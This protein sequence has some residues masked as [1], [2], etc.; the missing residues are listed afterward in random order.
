MAS[1]ALIERKEIEIIPIPPLREQQF[2]GRLAADGSGV[3]KF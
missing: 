2:L 1:V 3:G